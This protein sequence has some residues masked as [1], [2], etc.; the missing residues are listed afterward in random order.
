MTHR[1]AL[2]A[3]YSSDLQ[4]ESSVEDQFRT[5]R[6]LA[7]RE[8]WTV[9][10]EV[11]DKATSG[12]L[13]DRPGLGR[14]D[15][16]ITTRQID[17]VVA[18]SLDR[19]HRDVA[20]LAGLFKRA[21]FHNVRLVTVADGP[22][23]DDA[24]GQLHVALR[25][26]MAAMFLSDLSAKTHRGVEGRIR[27]GR[28]VGIAPYGYR[29]VRRLRPDGEPERG[30]REIDEAEALVVRRIFRA[31][32]EG[33]SPLR[34]ARLLNADGIP[35]PAGGAWIED[36]IR[37]RGQRLDGILHSPIYA[38]RIVWNRR[39]GLKDPDDGR[40]VRRNRDPDQFVWQDV[41]DLRIIDAETWEAVQTRLA[42]NRATV[43]RQPGSELAG[44]WDRR[45]P[46]FLLSKKTFCGICG[47]VLSTVGKD[48][49][50]CTRGRNDACTNRHTIRRPILTKYVVDA[51][52]E[53]LMRPELADAFAAAYRDAWNEARTDADVQAHS[54]GT[55]IADLDRRIGNLVDAL[56]DGAP[57]AP[58]RAKLDALQAQRDTLIQSTT[59][60]AA[61]I[62]DLPTNLGERYA[63]AL[64]T[65]L[66]DIESPDNPA[67]LEH[68]RALIDRVTVSP[69][70]DGDDD[71]TITLEGHLTA[72]LLLAINHPNK[73]A[74]TT[75]TSSLATTITSSAKRD[76]GATPLA[77][78]THAKPPARP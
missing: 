27:A 45:R 57:R 54:A 5:C 11:A 33:M 35:G 73:A 62:P 75:Q 8:G 39:Q 18:E 64:E 6:R 55:D 65:L 48:Y 41:P 58:I 32:A 37:G 2:Y 16:L 10:D 74:P 77:L 38:G 46:R 76:P 61:P 21:S 9:I 50:A 51:L 44:Y 59:T 30:L 12:A 34:I 52:R 25:G 69:P 36:S 22:V 42:R 60:A 7:A 56:A 78:L 1:V 17:V 24:M 14:L 29:A 70:S 53:R 67:A 15:A 72:L 47:D 28:M 71:P 13:R 23:R 20:N 31:Y 66:P 63:A 40:R 68:A 3:R 4:N 43:T 49:L 26:G 19:L